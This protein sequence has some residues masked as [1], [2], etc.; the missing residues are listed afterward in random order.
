[1]STTAG[2]ATPAEAA[3]RRLARTI[4]LGLDLGAPEEAG[5]TIDVGDQHLERVAQAGF[6]AVRLGACYGLHRRAAD[7]HQLQP[8]ALERLE[9]VIAAASGRGL[10]VVV[11]N[12]RDPQLMADPPRHRQR[13]LAATRQLAQATKHHGPGV[14]L[15][16]LSEPQLALD[17]VWNSYL[18]DLCA[19]VREIDPGRTLVVGPR[20]YNNTR[21][22][23]SSNSPSRTA[24]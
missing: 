3:N 2:T 16:P 12:L 22:L 11:A 21:F 4:N 10:A 23:W 20:S 9:E 19:A 24:T 1:M 7:S 5:W 6:S 17:R 13:L 14:V 15:E 8:R 18:R